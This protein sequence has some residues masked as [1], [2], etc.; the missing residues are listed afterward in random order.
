[1]DLRE[2]IVRCEELAANAH[3]ALKILQYDGW[4]LHFSEGH[5]GRANS[6][7]VLYPSH[8]DPDEKI[9]YCEKQYASQKLP[10]VFKL[11]DGD[12]AL[13]ERLVARGY[14]DITP[15]A[16]MRTEV[17]DV[18]M[19]QQEVEVFDQP[20]EEWLEPYFA[21]EGFDEKH[22]D[23]YRRM[24]DKLCIDAVY[25]VVKEQGR[26]V[27]VASAVEDDGQMLIQNVIVDADHRGKGYGRA[28]CTALLAKHAEEGIPP[29]SL[30][31]LQN[32]TV[33]RSLYE[34]LGFRKVYGYCY[35]KKA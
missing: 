27:A 35:M 17:F 14:T 5:T 32:N 6:V 2:Q 29:C 15:S 19:P 25:A 16:V 3:V 8:I 28:V 30:Q 9:D 34:S 26:A 33:A 12:E 11:T 22:Q 7:S 20:V 4:I 31:V 21:F 23:I 10:C 24:L 18:K 13:M 1:M